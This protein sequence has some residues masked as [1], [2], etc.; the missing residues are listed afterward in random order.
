MNG[1]PARAPLL[2]WLGGALFVGSLSFFAWT[3]FVRFADVPSSGA[4][5]APLVVN[6]LLFGV[7]A[8]HHSILARSGAKRWVTRHVPLPLER[9]LYVCV[10]SVL[11]IGVCAWWQDLPGRLYR[12]SDSWALPH[13]AIVGL[14]VLVMLRATATIDPLELAGIRQGA[15]KPSGG[16]F[17]VAGPYR[18]VRHPIYLGWVL[19]VFGVPD[20]TSTRLAF[21]AISTAYLVIAIPFEERSLVE[22]FGDT[23]RGYQRTVRSRLLPGVW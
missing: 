4:F 16:D 6:T 10:A 12:Q 13:W 22:M 14:G 19:I 11:F 20:M 8:L 18:F 3:Y 9:T 5:V 7:F 2:S 21:A 15:G 1:P 17:K 23:Y